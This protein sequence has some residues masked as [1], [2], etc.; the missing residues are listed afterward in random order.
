[1]ISAPKTISGRRRRACSQNAHGVGPQCRRFIRFRIMSSPDCSDKCRCGISRGSSAMAS[2]RCSSASTW[3]ID[4]S[5]S[6]LSS[7]TWRRIWRTSRPSVMSPGRSRTVRGDVDAR[8]HDLGVARFDEAA[9][10]RHDLAGGNRARGSATVGN[11]AECAAMVA[12]VLHLHIGAGP[13]AETVEHGMRR[14]AHRH[15]VVD[16]D[17]R[18]VAE[19]RARETSR[20]HLLGVADDRRRPPACPQSAAARSARHN[21]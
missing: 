1:M 13:R 15:D 7:G 16:H 21:R 2:I 20:A 8:D 19:A 14:L 17:P 10:L 12:A 18:A 5:R 9:H 4:D 11:D 3:S 6:R